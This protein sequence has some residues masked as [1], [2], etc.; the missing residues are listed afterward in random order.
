M[1]AILSVDFQ[2]YKVISN[3]A[4]GLSLALGIQALE[5]NVV[6]I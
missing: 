6:A 2:F 1:E 3:K 4:L 5:C